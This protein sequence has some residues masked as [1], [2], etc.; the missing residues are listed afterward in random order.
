MANYCAA[1][2]LVIQIP[3]CFFCL[4]CFAEKRIQI[5]SFSVP[6]PATQSRKPIRFSWKDAEKRTIYNLKNILNLSIRDS[7]K[8]LLPTTLA[9]GFSE[10]LGGHPGLTYNLN[11]SKADFWT[12][13]LFRK[14]P[15]VFKSELE[16]YQ[17]FPIAVSLKPLRLRA[18]L[19]LWLEK[20]QTHISS[21]CFLRFDGYTPEEISEKF[22]ESYYGRLPTLS[23]L[24]EAEWTQLGTLFLPFLEWSR[25]L[26]IRKFERKPRQDVFIKDEAYFGK[27]Y[28]L[29]LCKIFGKKLDY[30]QIMPDPC[31]NPYVRS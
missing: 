11:E 24:Q 12:N 22:Y 18:S 27:L 19:T 5:F 14:R 9:A 30:E 8:F 2:L 6:Y 23:E 7:T 26:N 29:W 4:Q 13:A 1:G 16:D 20:C 15:F 10:Q 21:Y 25:I 31:K 3:I 28:V 17:I